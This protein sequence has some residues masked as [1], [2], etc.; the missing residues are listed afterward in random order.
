MR[1]V[2]GWVMVVVVKAWIIGVPVTPADM[3]LESK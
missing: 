2:L 1:W 3:E